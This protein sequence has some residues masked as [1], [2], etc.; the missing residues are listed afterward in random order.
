MAADFAT[1]NERDGTHF[2]VDCPGCGYGGRIGLPLDYPAE[3]VVC[4]KCR[5]GV[6]VKPQDRVLWR[7]A[8]AMEFL[9][10]RFPGV[11][12]DANNPPSS[13]TFDQAGL[14]ADTNPQRQ[15]AVAR[16]SRRSGETRSRGGSRPGGPRRAPRSRFGLLSGI[17]DA[18]SRALDNHFVQAA[19]MLAAGVLP[20]AIVLL[21]QPGQP[22]QQSGAQVA[23]AAPRSA[24]K[25]TAPEPKAAPTQQAPAGMNPR[26]AAAADAAAADTRATDEATPR[27]SPPTPPESAPREDPPLPFAPD[28]PLTLK[29]TPADIV[30]LFLDVYDPGAEQVDGGDKK[31]AKPIMKRIAAMDAPNAECLMCRAKAH[32]FLGDFAPAFDDAS[33]AIQLASRDARTWHTRAMIL[34]DAARVPEALNDIHLAVV[35]AKSGRYEPQYVKEV[36]DYAGRLA[37]R[38]D[39]E[40]NPHLA[41]PAGRGNAGRPAAADSESV[42]LD[43]LASQCYRRGVAHFKQGAYA[44]AVWEFSEAIR[45]KPDFAASYHWRAVVLIEVR[46]FGAAL[47]DMNRSLSLRPANPA[48]LH[49][50]A[51]LLDRLGRYREAYADIVEAL[52]LSPGNLDYLKYLSRLR[53][54]I[55]ARRMQSA[56]LSWTL[57]MKDRASS[58]AAV[59]AADLLAI[60]ASRRHD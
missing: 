3:V 25:A 16:A 44:D 1:D 38:A 40:R 39:K 53:A 24:P 15:R 35:L 30:R 43:L 4:P 22:A 5:E 19:L 18:V 52:R 27:G 23:D 50:R 29:R 49:A 37:K 9:R 12:W 58:P 13:A 57:S 46:Q 6:R 56:D 36:T 10:R 55:D 48:A 31:S 54:R 41:S 28:S 32:A 34:A 60:R 33:R 45:S 21:T 8:D 59:R 2:W 20:V 7:P 42:Q 14:R 17:T 51:V 26:G 47:A 11:D